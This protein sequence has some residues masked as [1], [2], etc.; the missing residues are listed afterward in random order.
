MI[1]EYRKM[2]LQQIQAF[3]SRKNVGIWGPVCAQHGFTDVPSFTDPNFK[4]NGL[5]VYEAIEKFMRDPDHAEW[6]I[7][8]EQWP[9][10]KGCSGIP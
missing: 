10:N 7:E 2:S 5:M 3:K 8:E 1:E 6:H 9:F 4:V